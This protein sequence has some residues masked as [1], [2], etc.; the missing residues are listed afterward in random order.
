MKNKQFIEYSLKD[1]KFEVSNLVSLN[2]DD[3]SK[4]EIADVLTICSEN[5]SYER[6]SKSK[7]T[8]ILVLLFWCVFI[9]I[10]LTSF[11]LFG[12]TSP[13]QSNAEEETAAN[14]NSRRLS[15]LSDRTL[16]SIGNKHQFLSKPKLKEQ[17]N[18]NSDTK[19]RRF[20]EIK[21]LKNEKQQTKNGRRLLQESENKTSDTVETDEKILSES[22]DLKSIT[23]QPMA[24]AMNDPNNTLT[25]DEN[26]FD[27]NETD[28]EKEF[29]KELESIIDGLNLTSPISNQ[30]SQNKTNE[31]STPQTNGNNQTETKNPK[32]ENLNFQKDT[33]FQY[34]FFFVIFVIIECLLI[35]LILIQERKKRNLY[36]N[37]MVFEET[38]LKSFHD[39]INSRVFINNCH[40]N[41]KVCFMSWFSIYCFRFLISSVGNESENIT[42]N[43]RSIENQDKTVQSEMSVYETID[44]EGGKYHNAILSLNSQL[45]QEKTS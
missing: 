41:R 23:N 5:Q 43:I 34:L 38:T 14:G 37:L 29:E 27:E 26:D 44:D 40:E 6:L 17:S 19:T 9:L 32:N 1:R 4:K 42:F 22:S 35:S 31:N 33:T 45:K 10:L 11:F 15:A 21:R 8:V 30:T 2:V 12:D 3:F 16:T 24:I 25:D 36:H 39:K 13:R 20:E 7:Q 28:E 18:E